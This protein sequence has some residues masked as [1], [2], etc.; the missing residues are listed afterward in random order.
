MHGFTVAGEGNGG[1]GEGDEFSVVGEEG[2]EVGVVLEEADDLE[3]ARG[4]EGGVG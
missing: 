1:E 4:M 3:E 2:G